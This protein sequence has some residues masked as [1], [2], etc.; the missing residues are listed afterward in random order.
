M[1]R[2][3]K[4]KISGIKKVGVLPFCPLKIIKNPGEL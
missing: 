2:A 3:K 1:R 4:I